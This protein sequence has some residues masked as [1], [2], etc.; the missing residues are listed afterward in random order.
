MWARWKDRLEELGRIGLFV[1]LAGFVVCMIAMSVGI[2]HGLLAS[3]PWL[4]EHLP[5]GATTLVGAYA[6]TKAL[7][8]PRIVITVTITPFLA[9]VLGR[10]LV[11]AVAPAV[12]DRREG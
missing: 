6:L 5:T 8:V 4:A 7:S 2:Q 12:A 9:R 3:W 1:H 10:P 11:P